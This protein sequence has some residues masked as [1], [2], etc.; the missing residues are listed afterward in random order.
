MESG[1][2]E[3]KAEANTCEEEGDVKMKRVDNDHEETFPTKVLETWAL[4]N[5]RPKRQKVVVKK[6][7][8]KPMR[9]TIRWKWL[10]VARQRQW[11]ITKSYKS[12]HTRLRDL[13]I[14]RCKTQEKDGGSKEARVETS[15]C[16]K[17]WST[18]KYTT[19]V[20]KVRRMKCIHLRTSR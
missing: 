2:K 11:E 20:E 18:P 9:T 6:Q 4:T 13:G 15:A 5:V 3:V 10:R 1:D 16:N 8:S 19:K 14:N 17:S 12:L 7:R